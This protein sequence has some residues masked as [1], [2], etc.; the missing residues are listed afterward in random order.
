MGGSGPREDTATDV[1][2][3]GNRELKGAQMAFVGNPYEVELLTVQYNAALELILQ[4]KDSR[5]RGAV[6]TGTHVGKQAS[7]VQYIGP[8][9]FR[10]AGGRGTPLVPQTA[11]YQ[12]RWVTPA[13]YDLPVTV[14]T[15]DELRTIIDP[16]SALTATV[17]AAAGRLF[18]DIIINAYTKGCLMGV[19]PSSQTTETWNSGNDFPTSVV[20]ADTFGAGSSTGLTAAKIIEARRILRHYD[21]DMEAVKCHLVV[22][23]TQE[24]NLLSQIEVI[25]TEYR[26]RPVLEDGRIRSFLGCQFHYS[27][28]LPYGSSVRKTF[29]WLEDGMY[30][31]LWK[32]MQTI[33][34]QR[35]DLTGHPWQA[36]SM[37]SADATRL[38]AGK[39]IEIDCADSV[40]GPIQG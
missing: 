9:S 30:L 1:K 5:L 24:S 23:S 33:I 22:G 11:N 7:P 36:Y 4:Q 29:M 40:T 3:C 28:R 26:E 2:I 12:R 37:I 6:R 13:D 10:A 25:S 18:D 15:F 17:Q 34:S 31:G 27:E 32:D 14:D 35:N 20:V 39:I 19:D 8:L 16:K 21:N 38:Q